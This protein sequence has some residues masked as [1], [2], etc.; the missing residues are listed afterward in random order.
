MAVNKTLGERLTFARQKLAAARAALDCDAR[1]R[2]LDREI[3]KLTGIRDVLLKARDEAPEHERRAHEEVLKLERMVA[4]RE[5]GSGTRKRATG[6]G[7][8]KLIAKR[9]KLLDQLKGL[10]EIIGEAKR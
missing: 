8:D 10:D 7:L 9:Q 1:V 3:S 5:V 2:E 4:S 6:S